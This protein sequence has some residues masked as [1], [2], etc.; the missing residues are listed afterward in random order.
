MKQIWAPWRMR[1]ILDA[2]NAEAEPGCIFCPPPGEDEE[3][4]I[5][6]REGGIIVLMNRFPY[7]N[8]HLLIAPARH[9]GLLEDLTQDEMSPLFVA[10]QRSVRAL[11]AALHP[12]GLNIGMNQ[13]RVA[14]AGIEDHL[15]VHIVPRW[16]GDHNFMPVLGEVR[17]LNEHLVDTYKKLRPYFK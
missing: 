7:T 15:H 5:L 11:K 16:N 8:G 4:S 6:L 17:V 3:R 13:G 10:V 14:G 1:Y 9:A 2:D 12:H